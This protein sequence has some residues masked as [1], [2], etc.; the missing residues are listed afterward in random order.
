MAYLE[1]GAIVRISEI[2]SSPVAI[3]A[4]SPV[5]TVIDMSLLSYV[6]NTINQQEK[7][8]LTYGQLQVTGAG[9]YVGYLSH[10]I[11]TSES[12]DA[13]A[14]LPANMRTGWERP[15][16]KG[17]G[18]MAIEMSCALVGENDYALSVELQ[19]ENYNLQADSAVT[20]SSMIEIL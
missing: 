6:H 2:T 15:A 1:Q 19:A 7:G 13:A 20:K 9:T 4:S 8:R 14:N 11:R 18:I 12:T 3:P 16:V 17:L 5:A 10:T